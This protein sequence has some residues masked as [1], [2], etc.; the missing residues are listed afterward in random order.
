M[1][2]RLMLFGWLLDLRLVHGVHQA[3]KRLIHGHGL[4]RDFVVIGTLLFRLPVIEFNLVEIL[5]LLLRLIDA[6]LLRFLDLYRGLPF[7]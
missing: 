2:G 6:Y 5:L 1:A 4:V 7:A 3:T